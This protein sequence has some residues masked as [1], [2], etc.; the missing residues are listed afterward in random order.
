MFQL[1]KGVGCSTPLSSILLQL[2]TAL[3]WAEHLAASSLFLSSLNRLESENS[4]AS[5][6]LVEIHEVTSDS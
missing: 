5:L 2:L 3:R 1:V 4:L 6:A